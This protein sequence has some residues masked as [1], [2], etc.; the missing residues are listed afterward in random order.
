MDDPYSLVIWVTDALSVLRGSIVLR[1]TT[2]IC[3][4]RVLRRHQ[5]A[6]LLESRVPSSGESRTALLSRAAALPSWAAS[7][8][9]RV[10]ALLPW[11]TSLTICNQMECDGG[12]WWWLNW[13]L[14]SWI[15]G[16][17]GNGIGILGV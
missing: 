1:L 2:K 8:L 3:R 16:G 6:S 10:T 5:C 15:G 7:P 14:P 13:R 17:I 12:E 9:S 11:V 4:L